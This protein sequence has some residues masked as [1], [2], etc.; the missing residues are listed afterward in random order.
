MKNFEQHNEELNYVLLKQ[1]FLNGA[2][3]AKD[4]H[5]KLLEADQKS[6]THE[7]AYHNLVFLQDENV[8]KFITTQPENIQKLFER[9]LGF[10]QWHIAQNLMFEDKN[11]EGLEFF[12]KSVENSINGGSEESWI[13]YGQG[14]IAYLESDI[15]SLK[16]SIVKVVTQEKN[17]VI[18]ERMLVRLEKGESP[19]YKKDY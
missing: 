2:I 6:G 16:E 11:E 17:K 19:D 13:A 1:D 14:T 3:G 10:T 9:F 15:D 8:E 4:V 12:K 7:A 5:L 18:L